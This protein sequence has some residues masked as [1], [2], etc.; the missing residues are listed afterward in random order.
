[1][2]YLPSNPFK[3]WKK[4]LFPWCIH[5]ITHNVSYDPID[6]IMTW[7]SSC[8]NCTSWNVS[9]ASLLS[10]VFQSLH[11]KVYYDN[12]YFS[13]NKCCA[14]P[15]ARDLLHCT[16]SSIYIITSQYLSISVLPHP[17]HWKFLL[18][19]PA[20]PPAPDQTPFRIP[21]TP[22]QPNDTFPIINIASIINI[23]NIA[24]SSKSGHFYNS[25]SW[26]WRIS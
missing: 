14:V 16:D 9:C 3:N 17:P 26:Y 19:P 20:P 24:Y 8:D 22:S 7:Y 2:L 11:Y 5:S 12:V 15:M 21:Q 13:F 4:S 6:E 18:A 10:T 23:I 25:H 1:M